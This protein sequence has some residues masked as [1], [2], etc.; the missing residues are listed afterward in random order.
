[1]PLFRDTVFVAKEPTNPS[2]YEFIMETG[3]KNLWRVAGTESSLRQR[4]LS[5][6]NASILKGNGSR[7]INGGIS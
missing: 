2:V 6:G 7:V 4:D 3:S 1:M 5:A